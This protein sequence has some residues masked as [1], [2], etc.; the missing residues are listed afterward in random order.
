MT[1]LYHDPVFL[2]HETGRHPENPNRLRAVAARLGQA[3]L[4]ARCT[5]GE[6]E[7]LSAEA[8][9]RVHSPAVVRRVEEASRGGGGGY[10]DA[11][12]VVSPESYR[13]GLAAAG[14]CVAAGDAVLR[15]ADRTALC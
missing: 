5:P 9:A 2:R 10:L 7:P 8:L 6:F 12:T 1:L 15:G 3:G 13:V 11:D 4:L 14:A